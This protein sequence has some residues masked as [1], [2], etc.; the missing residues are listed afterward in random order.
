M[1]F[2][3]DDILLARGKFSTLGAERRV[4]LKRVQSSCTL[5]MDQ[6]SQIMRDAEKE[7]PQQVIH[8]EAA[9]TCLEDAGNARAELVKVCEAMLE[10]REKAWGYKSD[11]Q[12]SEAA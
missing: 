7:P 10:L 2:P 1:M 11:V 5:L 3:A 4:L 9:L 8:L 12:E 6:A